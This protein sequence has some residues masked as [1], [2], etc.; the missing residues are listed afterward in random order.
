M[1]S[2]ILVRGVPG[3]GKSTFSKNLVDFVHYET[4]MWMVDEVGEYKFSPSR[5]KECHNFCQTA[6]RAALMG[7]NNVVVSNTF[8]KKWEMA[9]YFEMAK[10]LGVAV[11]VVRMENS[12]ENVHGVPA[13][14]V[15]RMKMN[16]EDL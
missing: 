15:K 7:G 13:A 16:I 1:P 10:E 5:L 9:P 12:F 3:S 8:I 4:D 11:T 14:T 6:T 2:L